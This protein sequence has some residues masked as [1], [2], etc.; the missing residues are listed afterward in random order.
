MDL[1]TVG[2]SNHPAYVFIELLKSAN[3]SM[4][5]DVRAKPASRW[6][7][8][9]GTELADALRKADI[10]YRWMGRFLG[11]TKGGVEYSVKH[12]Q[13]VEA[14]K[15]TLRFASAGRVALM[16]SEGKPCDCHRAGK[17]TAYLHRNTPSVRTIH[18]MPDGQRIDAKTYEPKVKAVV[19]CEELT[20]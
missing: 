5:L 13:F 3:I 17:L 4:I 15:T 14:M 7:Q 12:P 19:W 10:D 6:P 11:G 20:R 9:N 1:F 18:I 2:H 8:Y 16:C